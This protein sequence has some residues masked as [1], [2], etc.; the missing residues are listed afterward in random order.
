MTIM[1]PASAISKLAILN[2]FTKRE[3][4]DMCNNKIKISPLVFMANKTEKESKR[5]FVWWCT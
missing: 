2:N 1:N 5:L 3:A 4:S